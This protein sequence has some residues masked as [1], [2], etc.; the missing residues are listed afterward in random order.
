MTISEVAAKAGVNV[1]TLRYYERRGI[2]EEPPRTAAGYRQY[3]PEA[4]SRV[5]FIK[6]AQELGFALDE[7]HQLLGLRVDHG[8]ACGPVEAK[9]RENLARVEEKI[10]QLV[11]MR[12]VLSE[13]V[14]ACQRRNGTEECPILEALEA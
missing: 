5:R 4:V 8:A 9:A 11:R 12:E 2:L 3:E 14:E 13:L 10:R 7:A 6:R 1:Q